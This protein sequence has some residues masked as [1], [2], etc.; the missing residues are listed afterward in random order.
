MILSIFSKRSYLSSLKIEIPFLEKYLDNKDN[1]K[2]T[3]KLSIY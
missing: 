2:I 3:N 1:I